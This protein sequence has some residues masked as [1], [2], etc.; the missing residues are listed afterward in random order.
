METEPK[1]ESGEEFELLEPDPETRDWELINPETRVKNLQ[2]NTVN[3]EVARVS[4][5][6]TGFTEALVHILI[7]REVDYSPSVSDNKLSFKIKAES[8]NN[9]REMIEEA[10]ALALEYWRDDQLDTV[11]IPPAEVAA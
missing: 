3:L 8:E 6:S 7:L 4:E 11:E 5:S 2:D 9:V 10:R 1:F